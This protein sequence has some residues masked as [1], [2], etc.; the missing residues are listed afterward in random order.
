[1]NRKIKK[2]ELHRET[3][4]E[5]ADRSLEAA[6]GGVSEA[7]TCPGQNTCNLQCQ[8]QL[9]RRCSVCCV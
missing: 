3:V 2:L 5:L 1:M 8:T 7:G 4:R 9:T 6:A